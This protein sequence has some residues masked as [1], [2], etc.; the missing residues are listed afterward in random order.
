MYHARQW[1]VLPWS[2]APAVQSSQPPEAW[3][4]LLRAS[5]A[6]HCL[7]KVGQRQL[8]L[9]QQGK[10]VDQVLSHMPYVMPPENKI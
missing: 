6:Q 5:T 9:S 2:S 3:K 4:D 7:A 1:R 8:K 10:E